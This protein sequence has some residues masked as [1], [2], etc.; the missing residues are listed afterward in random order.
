MKQLEFNFEAVPEVVKEISK[1]VESKWPRLSIKEVRECSSI[2]NEY[3]AG[4]RIYR[5]CCEDAK[6]Q[7]KEIEAGRAF[8][9]QRYKKMLKSY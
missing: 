7:L 3:F 9:S 6:H 5:I 4:S 2:E 8:A 1:V